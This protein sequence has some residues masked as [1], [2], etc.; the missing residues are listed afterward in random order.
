[1]TTFARYF[2]PMKR[3]LVIISFF[4]LCSCS[5]FQQVLKSED[6]KEKYDLAEK[7]YNEGKYKK[8]SRLFEQIMPKYIGKPQGERILFFHA[9]TYYKME[10]FYLAAYQFER[11]SKSYPKSEKAEEASFLGAKS[12]F[13]LSPR[14]SIDQKETN[15]GIDKLQNFINQYPNS[16][17]VDEANTLMAELQTKLEKKAFEIAKQYNTIRDYQSAI[18]AFDNFIADF[19]G[20]SFREEAQFYKLNS[21]FELAV[22]SYDFVKKERLET[23]QQLYNN[24]TKNYRDSEYLE[25]AAEMNEVAESQLNELQTTEK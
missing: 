6:A 23:V 16:L 9:D 20:T 1:M 5:E 15:Q 12:Y 7:L 8:A 24:F 11:F 4:T 21:A 3:L 2:L 25:R 18:N 14:Y 17:L 22:N 10:D 13:M 19:P